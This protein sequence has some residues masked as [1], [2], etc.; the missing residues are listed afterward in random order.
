[1]TKSSKRLLKWREENALRP[2]RAIMLPKCLNMTRL[3]CPVPTHAC[4]RQRD[5][6]WKSGPV[7]YSKCYLDRCNMGWNAEKSTSG[8]M[9]YWQF[10]VGTLWVIRLNKC[11]VAAGWWRNHAAS[12]K[13]ANPW[14]W[15]D[16]AYNCRRLAPLIDQLSHVVPH[17]LKKEKASSWKKPVTKTVV[18]L[19]VYFLISVQHTESCHKQ[20]SLRLSTFM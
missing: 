6:S 17:D 19:I 4:A 8:W 12:V 20:L 1:M 7:F 3:R 11:A 14:Q 13:R 18:H 15:I 16:K 2:Y 10:F 9:Q 5:L